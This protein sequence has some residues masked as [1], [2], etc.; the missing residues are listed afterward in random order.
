MEEIDEL[1]SS[2]LIQAGSAGELELI[3]L[4]LP[5]VRKIRVAGRPGPLESPGYS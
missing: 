2:A 4:V 5:V 3:V 1:G